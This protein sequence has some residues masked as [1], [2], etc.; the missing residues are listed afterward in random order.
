[1]RASDTALC[2]PAVE[3]DQIFLSQLVPAPVFRRTRV[4]G[5]TIRFGSFQVATCLYELVTMLW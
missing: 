1:M 4:F 5:T 2:L 3:S